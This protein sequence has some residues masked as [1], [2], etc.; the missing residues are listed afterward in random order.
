MTR[1]IY[2][3]TFSHMATRE[4]SS[5]GIGIEYNQF[6]ISKWLDDDAIDD[7]L[8]RMRGQ[9]VKC[10]I[11]LEEDRE[12]AIVHGPFC[13]IA[14][15]SFD[16]LFRELAMKRLDQAAAGTMK[17]GLR[18]M[19]VHTGYVPQ[20]FYP[21][22]HIK[23]SIG[24]WQSFLRDKP[25][26]FNVYLENV[27]DEEPEMLSEI[28]VG[29]DDPRMR[30]CLDVGHVNVCSDTGVVRWIEKIGPL[31][32]HF[33]LH[34]NDGKNDLHAP[35]TEGTIDMDE[36]LRAI[37]DFCPEDATLTIESRKCHESI[38]WLLDRT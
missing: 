28:V 23:E 34:N 22:W 30:I 31:I 2:L 17:L 19:V 32:A 4:I 20:I 13:E 27:M 10:G 1:Q 11:D 15:A 5:Y 35:L 12:K 16:H 26:D 14:P 18:R 37:D 6:C 29:V 8:D 21:E 7:T 9:A 36:V 3:S 24:F 33:H 25:D 38:R